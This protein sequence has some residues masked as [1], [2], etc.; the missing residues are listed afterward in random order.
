MTALCGGGKEIV[1]FNIRMFVF[2]LEAG[3]RKLSQ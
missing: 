1:R 2:V 3:Q